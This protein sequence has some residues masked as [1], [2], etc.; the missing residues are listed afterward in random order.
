MLQ[1]FVTFIFLFQIA[2]F[3]VASSL[4]ET[5]DPELTATS[6]SLPPSKAILLSTSAQNPNLAQGSQTSQKAE[7]VKPSVLTFLEWREQV[8]ADSKLR[9]EALRLDLS[10][11]VDVSKN[12]SRT[13]DLRASS[14]LID[15]LKRKIRIE[16]MKQEAAIELSLREY[17]VTYLM[18]SKDSDQ[19]INELS[20]R[21]SAAEVAQLLRSYAEIV[22]QTRHSSSTQALAPNNEQ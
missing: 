10:R 5:T 8:A 1:N 13:D 11:Q 15:D 3:S 18:A 20:K 4:N 17:F 2:S 21:L 19:R 9:A 7:A 12:F 16:R 22:N 14:H 6:K